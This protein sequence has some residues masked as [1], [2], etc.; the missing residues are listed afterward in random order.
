MIHRTLYKF[1]AH[2][3]EGLQDCQTEYAEDREEQ[4]GNF[5]LEG[6]DLKYLKC[7]E[8]FDNL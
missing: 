2:T 1:L 3:T 5:M 4:G 7:L 6:D 8:C